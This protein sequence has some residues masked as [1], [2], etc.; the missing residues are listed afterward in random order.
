MPFGDVSK[1][2]WYAD[3]VAA[4]YQAG[5]VQGIA[6]DKFAPTQ[7]I[8]REEMAVLMMRA[9]EYQTQSNHTKL[10]KAGYT[11]EANIASWAKEAVVK[12]SELGVMKGSTG[13]GFKPKNSATRAETAQTVHNL[14]SLLK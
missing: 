7:T 1:D 6:N 11:D 2:A 14:L 4:A 12:A 9:Y 5:L 10:A 3:S 13:G 8:S